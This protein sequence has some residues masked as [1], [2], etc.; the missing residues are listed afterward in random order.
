MSVELGLGGAGASRMNAA[1]TIAPTIA[2]AAEH[3]ERVPRVAARREP[4]R[5][6]GAARAADRHRGLPDPEREPALPRGE[7]AHHRAA[8]RR[9]DARAERAADD[10][11]RATSAA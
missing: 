1:A 7:P 2:D 4:G 11:Q 6:R 9:V 10:E 3:E 8:A 5:S